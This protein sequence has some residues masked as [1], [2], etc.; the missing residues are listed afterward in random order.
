MKRVRERSF[1]KGP[2]ASYLEPDGEEDD[3][4]EG[5]SISKIKNQYKRG[6]SYSKYADDGDVSGDETKPDKDDDDSDFV[7]LLSFYI[8]F[9]FV[10]F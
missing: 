10:L 3:E 8:L 6:N 1:I 4:E 5:I 7:S 9:S 2:T